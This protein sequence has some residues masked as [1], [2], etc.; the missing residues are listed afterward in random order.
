MV[1]RE[2]I[3]KR[4]KAALSGPK[5]SAKGKFTASSVLRGQP[6][7]FDRRQEQLK[8]NEEAKQTQQRETQRRTQHRE[9]ARR[10]QGARDQERMNQQREQQREAEEARR[11]EM[12]KLEK[13]GG[14]RNVVDVLKIALN[15]FSKKRITATTENSGLNAVLEA[16]ANNPYT[17]A[18]LMVGTAALVRGA[19]SAIAT[20]TSRTAVSKAARVGTFVI[21]SPSRVGGVAATMATNTATTKATASMLSKIA[22]AAGVSMGVVSAAMPII[23]S[24]PFAGFIKEEALQTIDWALTA[25]TEN[26][27]MEGAAAAT[28][29]QEELLNP[30]FWDGIKAKVPFLNVLVQLD[31]F[32]KAS[33]IKLD[34]NKKVLS[35]LKYQIEFGETDSQMYARIADERTTLKEQER[36]ADEIYYQGIADRQVEAKAA[37]R[38][39]DAAYYAGLSAAAAA[40]AK[41]KRADDEAYWSKKL[42]DKDAAA[43]AKRRLEDD[44]WNEYYKSLA[45]FKA[46]S[47]PSNL[48]FGL[49]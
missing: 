41:K 36:V 44:Y 3:A 14:W 24:Y 45:K 37:S 4:R 47:A 1:T 48:K 7:E 34:V 27:D 38:V 5:V 43:A 30:D 18:G 46:N 39:A 31:E 9:S 35:D 49:L 21:E 8:K 20:V 40:A 32:Y 28:E 22:V 15:P 12:Q 33:R 29:L 2:G 17:T 26:G 23:G 13:P 10:D 42:A 11:V 6:T 19:S 25:A 16:V